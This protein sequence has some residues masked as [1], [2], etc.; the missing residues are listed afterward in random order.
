MF[1]RFHMHY[2]FHDKI[3]DILILV[4]CLKILSKYALTLSLQEKMWFE[5][6]FGERFNY[7]KIN[8]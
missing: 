6:L 4:G 8:N 2:S 3:Y 7:H 1:P 5:I